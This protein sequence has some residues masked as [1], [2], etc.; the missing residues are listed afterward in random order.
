MSEFIKDKSKVNFTFL[1]KN[2]FPSGKYFFDMKGP[3][4]KNIS[5][6]VVHNNWVIG[7]DT[8]RK[9]FK[10]NGMW[11]VKDDFNWNAEESCNN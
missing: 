8:K 3:Q 10:D 6:V 1:D 9:R 7:G 4:S 5:P 2:R 11:Y